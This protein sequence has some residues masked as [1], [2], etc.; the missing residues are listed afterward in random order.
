MEKITR[1]DF[2]TMP[3]KVLAVAALAGAMETISGCASGSGAGSGSHP[4]ILLIMVD[5]MQ[6]PP[7]G[8]KSGEGAVE[9]LKEILGFRPLS[10]N[11]AY[12]KFFPGLLRL[13]QNAVVLRKHYTA[14][15]A[16]VPSRT[17][18]MTGQYP[19][20]TG[21]YHT[22]GLF[23]L[24]EDVPFLDPEGTPT[25]GDWFRAAGYTTHY[26]GKWHVSEVKQN[27]AYL[28]PF[29]FAD[30]EKSY[31]DAHAGN[32]YNS[33]TFRDIGIAENVVEFL[34]NRKNDASGKPWLA[35]GSLLNPHD[36]SL[37]PIIWEVPQDKGVVPW[38]GVKTPLKIPVQGQQ[39]L[40]G[41]VCEGT[42]H[43]ETITVDLNPKGFPQENSALPPTYDESLLDKPR[44]Q[45]DYSL[46]WGLAFGAKTDSGFPA[47]VSPLPFQLQ[48]DSRGWS[49]GYNQ[50]YF[51]CHYLADIQIDNIL[52]ALDQ[53]GLADNTIVVFLSDHGDM[54]G[55]HGGMIQKWHSAYEEAIRVPMVISSP[56]V[57]NNKQT[58]REI[59]EPTSSIDFAPTV[60][61]LAGYDEEQIRRQMEK[62]GKSA[63]KPFAGADLS[64]QIKGESKSAISGT[65]GT[66]RTGVFFMS[67]DMVTALGASKYYE[68]Q[69]ETFKTYV[70]EAID[71]GHLPGDTVLG[72]VRQ[73]NNVRAW[74]T[75]DWKIVHYVDPNHVEADEWELYCLTADPLEK[76]NLVNFATG[77]VRNDVTVTG[78]TQDQLKE[79]NTQLKTE[80]A[81]QEAAIIG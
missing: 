28:E 63:I 8:Y 40:E 22:D 19:S 14:S 48:K 71:Q 70:Q 9:E 7:E 81:R 4:N 12:A 45:K 58:M 6:T 50:F 10:P 16:C 35:V 65:D 78:M 56:L 33:G 26:F 53:N 68:E 13:R 34:N 36:C 42:D 38:E 29:G 11:N 57:N 67:N 64:A 32:A 21:V 52:K 44:C 76:I 20:T 75:G 47:R 3:P 51:Y 1:R 74:C 24:P 2:I 55:A 73:P 79:K 66:K 54:T 72:E 49:V 77:E 18:I 5:Q 69:Y 46:K 25:I 43:E 17:C 59:A 15:A 30:W 60:L 27:S 62:T 41:T 31:P 23:K 37:W 39:S 80:L 61:A